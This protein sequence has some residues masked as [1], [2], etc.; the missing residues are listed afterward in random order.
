[1]G[2]VCC[3]SA[4]EDRKN[5]ENIN[6]ESNYNNNSTINY[7]SPS[8]GAKPSALVVLGPNSWPSPEIGRS[9]PGGPW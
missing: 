2:N 3:S 7:A 9:G 4:N 5:R 8:S 6:Q 1:M